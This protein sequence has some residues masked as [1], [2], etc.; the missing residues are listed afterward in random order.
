MA[1]CGGSFGRPVQTPVGRVHYGNLRLVGA[2]G[3]S[4][5]EALRR[6]PASGEVR[7]G[8]LVHVVGA[9]GPMGTMAVIRL[10]SI[11]GQGLSV[12]AADMAVDRLAVLERKA[13]P[14][15]R[16][17]G[18][19]L[20]CYNPKEGRP[21]APATYHM[22]M[23][24]VPALVAAA[25]AGSAPGAIVNIFAGIPADVSGPVDLDA[26]CRLGCY[27]VGTSGSTMDDMMAVLGK[28]LHDE[29]DTNLSVGAVAGIGGAI[30]G[31]QAVKENRIAGKILVYPDLGAFPLTELDALACRFP[32][33]APLL[34]GGCWSKAAEDELLRL[35]RSGGA[36]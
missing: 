20:R 5:A 36:A 35:A 16:A 30:A 8:D 11:P 25:V 29:L 2:P 34:A 19:A 18:V 10:C 4:F 33:L 24:P 28:V 21:S 7:R 6:I 1:Q 3:A 22:V 12:E 31:L 23:V 26:Y 32:S 27:L 14:V 15:A 17:R 9:A 13:A